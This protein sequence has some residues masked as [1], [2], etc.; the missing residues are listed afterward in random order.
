MGPQRG[1]ASRS[2]GIVTVISRGV[3]VT[4]FASTNIAP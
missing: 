1:L 3:G 2:A 4:N